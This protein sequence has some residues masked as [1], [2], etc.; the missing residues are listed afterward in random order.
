MSDTRP[1]VLFLSILGFIN[2]GLIVLAA[3]FTLVMGT[4]AVGPSAVLAAFVYLVVAA[5]PLGIAYLMY[6]YAQ[7]IKEFLRRQD[8][9]RLERALAAQK[10]YWQVVGIIVLI[11]VA[12]QVIVLLLMLV[13]V[14]GAMSALSNM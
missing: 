1:W 4:M 8:A 6:A 11:V 2:G 12:L 7:R 13:G 14:M 9:R 10:T 3:L 5:L